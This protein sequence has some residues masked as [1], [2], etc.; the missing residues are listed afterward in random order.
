MVWKRLDDKY[1]DYESGC[2]GCGGCG[3]GDDGDYI[4]TVSANAQCVDEQTSAFY[5]RLVFIFNKCM[6]CVG[7]LNAIVRNFIGNI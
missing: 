2:G 5:A 4:Y 1:A 6:H 3:G 7:G